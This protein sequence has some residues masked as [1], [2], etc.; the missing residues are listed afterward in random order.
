MSDETGNGS[1]GGPQE[2]EER[3]DYYDEN[4]AWLGTAPRSEVHARGLWHRSIHC[5]LARREDGRK[6]VLFQQ[7]SPDKDTFPGHFDI[8]AAGHLTAGESM[9]DAAR[10]IEE[11]LGAAIPFESLLYLGEASKEIAGI[12]Q[13][14]AF[15]DREISDIYG[16]VYP[17]PLTS[18]TLQREEVSG[19]YE[20]ELEAMIA[21]FEGRL[22][23]VRCTGFRLGEDGVPAGAEALV[24]ASGFVPRPASYY[25]ETFRALLLHV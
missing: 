18:L 16:F 21:L 7:R 14:T 11:E 2:A 1:N 15:L 20:A 17:G 5:W 24:T 13:G 3:F 6:L 19:V 22:E 10:E 9:R 12:A 4:G 25:S 8:T 23:Q